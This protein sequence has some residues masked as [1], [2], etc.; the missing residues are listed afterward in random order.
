LPRCD[1]ISVVIIFSR[2]YAY[3]IIQIHRNFVRDLFELKIRFTL[4]S[5]SSSLEKAD[6][7]FPIFAIDESI[8]RPASYA[9][10]VGIH[11]M[12]RSIALSS[13]FALPSSVDEDMF[14][15]KHGIV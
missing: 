2:S 7:T 8:L 3:P 11:V 5:L 9:T 15:R 10:D 4:S 12:G 1:A 13:S 14:H 6:L